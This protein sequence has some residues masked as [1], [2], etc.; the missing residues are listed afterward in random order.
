[1][2]SGDGGAAPIPRAPLV[3]WLALC[4]LVIGAFLGVVSALNTGVYSAGGFVARYLDA[5]QR[6]DLAAALTTP[7]VTVP[8]GLSA[9]ALDRDALVGPTE[10]RI[11]RVLADPD[12]SRTVTAAYELAG[13]PHH[14]DFRV[15]PAAPLF[16]LFSGWRFAETPVGS[17]EVE[18]QGGSGFRVN[19]LAADAGAD[20]RVR[21][22][23]LSPTLA[24]LDQQNRYVVA[25]RQPVPIVGTAPTIA[26]V[27]LRASDAFVASVQEEVDDFLD[28]CAEQDVLQPAG[29]PFRRLLEDRVIER[30]DWSIA[31]YPEIDI[32][33]AEEGWLVPP[34]SG[35][36]HITVDMVSLF[37]GTVSTVDED[38]PFEVS[39]RITLRDDGGVEIRAA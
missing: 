36:A 7:G 38:V 13:R 18:V 39:Y 33:R 11:V 16:L 34:A 30:P 23:V 20:G 8:S 21:L 32:V 5:L 6:R 27:E 15:E 1:M 12:G 4:V 2:G 25:D 37:D 3:R 19:G 10:T 14:S 22:A 35:A 29:C 26:V 24:V 28:A 31:S 9:A 17:L